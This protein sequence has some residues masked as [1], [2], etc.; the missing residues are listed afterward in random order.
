MPLRGLE[1][2]DDGVEVA[3]RLCR[4]RP[5]PARGLTP[6]ALPP[7][8]LPRGPQQLVRRGVLAQLRA[9]LGERAGD[10]RRAS[11]LARVEQLEVDRVPQSRGEQLARARYDVGDRGH[12]RAGIRSLG[13]RRPVRTRRPQR[14]MP[15]RR[16]QAAHLDG[17][18]SPAAQR[19]E[20][21]VGGPL[22]LPGEVDQAQQIAHGAGLAERARVAARGRDFARREFALERTHLA[23]VVRDHG[24]RPP[25]DA[26]VQVPLAQEPGDEVI[27]LRARARRVR[28][29]RRV[30]TGA[31]RA[32]AVRDDT[33]GADA[34]RDLRRELRQHRRPPVRAVEDVDGRARREPS[35][36]L[37]TRT[38]ERTRTHIRVAER[39]HRDARGPARL[40]KFDAAEGQLL[41]VIDEEHPHA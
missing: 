23:T 17:I 32:A 20:G 18:Q 34:R 1:E 2:R 31:R 25:R 14:V 8:R 35:E 26:V 6:R 24:A 33:D 10:A 15:Q 19:V 21:V 38:A 12:A 41:R 22:V 39:E 30:E 3:P 16:A 13:L 37:R 27:L 11:P 5:V 29:H 4:E 40:E 36:V 9:Q 7:R 28:A